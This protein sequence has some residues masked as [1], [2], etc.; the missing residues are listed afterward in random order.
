MANLHEIGEDE[1]WAL[2][3]DAHF[4]HLAWNGS[5]GPT[6]LP[7]NLAVDDRTVWI[8]TGYHSSIA[9]E[10]DESRIAIL[11]DSIDPESHEGWSVQVRGVA[12]AEYSEDKVPES[13]RA[14]A[15]WAAGARPVWLRVKTTDINGRRLAE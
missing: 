12:H 11:V 2:L 4:A 3:S 14:L 10:A 6:I 5:D 7:V 1:S 9:R 8:R 15:T 13:V